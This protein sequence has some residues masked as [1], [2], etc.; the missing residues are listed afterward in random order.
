MYVWFEVLY[1]KEDC[2]A[3]ISADSII[4]YVTVNQPAPTPYSKYII[5]QTQPYVFILYLRYCH[6]YIVVHMY[7]GLTV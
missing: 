2:I 5:F 3:Y 1:A 6:M 4:Q 7:S